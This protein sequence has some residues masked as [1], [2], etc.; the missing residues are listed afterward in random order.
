M[1][2]PSL[3]AVFLAASCALSTGAT[4]QNVYKCGG[5]YSQLPCPGGVLI[6]TTDQRSAAQKAQ[7]DLATVRDARNADAMETARLQQEKKDL[8]ANTPKVKAQNDDGASSIRASQAKKKAPDYFTV[9]T[10]SE[11]KK[12][13]AP[14]KSATK[15]RVAKKETVKS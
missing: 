6:D 14:T 1:Q 13:Q 9:R 2:G 10:A 15:K 12:K 4:A 11:K 3:I 8:A 7:S 5:N